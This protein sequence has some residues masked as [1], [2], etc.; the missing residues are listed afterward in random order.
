MFFNGNKSILNKI[1]NN[2]N[3]LF[4]M[5]ERKSFNDGSVNE[6]TFK[7]DNIKIIFEEDLREHITNL[8]IINSQKKI[9]KVYYREVMLNDELMG[10]EE[11]K[12]SLSLLEN[13]NNSESQEIKIYIKFLKL[14]K[15]L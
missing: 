12:E 2:Y 6:I 9:G 11:L 10:V 5:W 7:K 3:P 13:K 15:I 14:N 4:E 1:L 8:F